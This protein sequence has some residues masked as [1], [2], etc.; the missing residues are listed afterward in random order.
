[1]QFQRLFHRVLLCAALVLADT[2]LCT[3]PRSW[4]RN[5]QPACCDNA[6]TGGIISYQVNALRLLRQ[7][8]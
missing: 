8:R 1:L 6:L 3:S 5:V 4:E 7:S 2:Y